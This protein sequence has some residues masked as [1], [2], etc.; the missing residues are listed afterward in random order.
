[1]LNSLFSKWSNKVK[2]AEAEEEVLSH[3]FFN[4][5]HLALN[6]DITHRCA[7]K[8]HR[9]ARQ[10]DYLD[11]GKKVPGRTLTLEEF[12][13]IS[14]EFK[15]ISFCGQHSDPTHHPQFIEILRKCNAKEI[16]T[17]VNVASTHRPEEWFIEAFK[18]QPKARWIFGIDGFPEESHKYRVNQDGVKLYKIMIEAKKYLERP[19]IWKFI[20]FRYNQDHIE[21]AM[22]MAA[23]NGLIFQL[24]RSV[25]WDCENGD[26][27]KPTIEVSI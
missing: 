15:N 25:R 12:E 22:K 2:S 10:I 11:K 8:C 5:E 3:P 23:D 16:N 19:P 18:A 27:M 20:I 17:E 26:E 14:D 1:M 24:T 6:I 7:L 9:C 13:L 4:R 21:E